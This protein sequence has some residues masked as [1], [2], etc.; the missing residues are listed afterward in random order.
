MASIAYIAAS[1]NRFN[2]AGDVSSESLLAFGS[3]RLVGLWNINDDIDS[4]ISATL[5][6][7]EG[8]VTCVRF[9]TKDVL[10]SADDKGTLL[11]WKQNEL[12]WKMAVKCQTHSKAI[13]S[14][15]VHQNRIVTGSSD[16]LVK[17][18]VFTQG[19]TD[20]VIEFQVIPLKGK[21]PLALALTYL[22]HTR[23][24]ILAIAGTD[25]AVQLWLQS[26]ETFVHSATL[27]GHEDWIRCLAFKPASDGEPL[28]LASG[29]QDATI[30]LWSIEAWRRVTSSSAASTSTIGELSDEL[31]DVFE[32]SLG[33]LGDADEG[34]KQI[35][36]K[37]HILST[38]SG[39]GSAGQQFSVTFDA[40]LVGHEGGI[41]SLAW[42]P[43]VKFTSTPTLLSTST[44]SS[45]IL[46]SPSTVSQ[47]GSAS[48]WINRQRFGDIGGQRLGGFVGGSWTLHGRETV[49]WGWA[50]ACRRWRC[51]TTFSDQSQGDE[52][53]REVGAISGH[54]G[55]VKGLSWSPRGEY[56]ISAGLDQTSRIHGNITA[57]NQS[58][59]WHELGRPQIH[60][61]DLLD[62]VFIDPLR[63]ASVA[64][65]KVVRI[66]EAPRRF[67]EVLEVLGVAQFPEHDH[68]RP[69]SANVPPLGL[70]NKAV[71][72]GSTC[73]FL[74][75][76]TS[77][78]TTQIQRPN[79]GELASLTL[80]PE[81]EKVFGHGYE[82]VTIAV[83]NSRHL[84]ATACKATSAEHAVVRVYDTKNYRPFGQPLLGHI[85]T[86]TRIAFSPDDK[87]V[88]S[89]S[90]DRSWRLFQIQE[91]LGKENHKMA[92]VT[93]EYY[94][95][96]Y[97]PV[98]ADKTHG[99]IIWDCAWAMEGDI[100]ATAS[101]DKTVKIWSKEENILHWSITTTIKTKAPATAVAF[102]PGDLHA[103][104]N[105]LFGMRHLAIGL[106]T[107]DIIIYSNKV[108]SSAS[109]W[110]IELS[111]DTSIAHVDHIHRLAWRPTIGSSSELASCSE[112]GTLRIL[113]VQLTTD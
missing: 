101:R 30:R 13:S 100:F 40:L 53:W 81:V 84:I 110:R 2:Q 61:Y 31:L 22:P 96:G 52:T 112:D 54:N 63:F 16:G 4:G 97:M 64:D 17:V 24:S 46:W 92:Y 93:T 71:G 43:D 32:A 45:L 86:V 83:S 18:W 94:I 50:G 107:G 103:R 26:E 11:L 47:D 77:I 95:K 27:A 74:Q 33:E 58:S 12:K 60:G 80:W 78:G 75:G 113:K 67:I 29:S 48:V 72:E 99:R 37:R 65:E 105:I 14:I 1:V 109:D 88:L 70:S 7:H 42:R 41:T 49:A 28:V 68:N 38:K 3:S 87:L 91:G 66:F 82:S 55:P 73:F 62:A 20:E 69:Q 44:D 104:Q 6:G 23:V 59:F 15:C 108:G 56:L 8:L 76:L 34:G 111:I 57:S 10:L 106:E 98:A 89:V 102:A 39:S 25:T 19:E 5:P 85:L 90:R 35:S 79:D 36:L 21:Y 51:S 9:L